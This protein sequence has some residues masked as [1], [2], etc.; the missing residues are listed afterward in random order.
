MFIRES[1]NKKDILLFI[2]FLSLIIIYIIRLQSFNDL[3][4]NILLPI[5]TALFMYILYK[6]HIGKNELSA[7]LIFAIIIYLALLAAFI[8]LIRNPNTI[9]AYTY[10]ITFVPLL[11]IINYTKRLTKFKIWIL[12]SIITI[13][14][15]ITGAR[16][17]LLAA[18][19]SLITATLWKFI[20]RKKSIF[21]GYFYFVIT[22]I[23]TITV[24]YPKIYLLESFQKYD[25]LSIEITGKSLYSGRNL[26][27]NALLDV[28]KLK[29][30]L[31]YGTNVQASDLT[32]TEQTS[33]NLY[34]KVSLETGLF[35]VLLLLIFFF[36]IWK[37]LWKNRNNPSACLTGSFIIGILIH[38]TF[39]LH[40]LPSGNSIALLQWIIIGLGLNY[41]NK[42]KTLNNMD[43]ILNKRPI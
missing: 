35:G 2:P 4:S 28:I 33:H 26:I 22:I 42:K 6:F 1:I 25:A 15:L 11:Y 19:F 17:A 23:F 12:L 21:Y 40:F 43:T 8:T 39:E 10:F 20:I 9:G 32:F 27:W 38:Q 7:F 37:S 29:P 30:I 34:L 41:S 24:L 14:I 13:F 36:V 5:S 31:G 3:S 16:T 18:I